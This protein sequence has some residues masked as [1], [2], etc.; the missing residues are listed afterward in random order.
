MPGA[1]NSTLMKYIREH[2]N[3]RKE[4]EMWSGKKTL[5]IAK[6]FLWRL[7]S[8]IQN[9]WRG[10]VRAL[11]YNLLRIPKPDKEGVPCK[12]GTRREAKLCSSSTR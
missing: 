3:T 7:G 12:V 4:L 1:G 5:V 9:N 8:D 6:V 10:L 11:L 2:P